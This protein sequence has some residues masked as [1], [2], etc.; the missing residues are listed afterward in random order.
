MLRHY[1]VVNRLWDDVDIAGLI[2]LNLTSVDEIVQLE[3]SSLAILGFL[4]RL[5]QLLL[6]RFKSR[7]LIFNG[8]LSESFLGFLI[9]DLPLCSSPLDA[10]FQHV[11]TSTI[12]SYSR[13]RLLL[14][15]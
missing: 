3:H 14:E 2:Q 11:G 5:I 9:S 4:F 1:R 6:K 15:I 12:L 8:L 13:E 10:C 7:E